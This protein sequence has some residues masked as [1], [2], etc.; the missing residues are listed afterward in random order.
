MFLFYDATNSS[1]EAWIAF[2]GVIVG[3]L[4]TTGFNWFLEEKKISTRTKEETRTKEGKCLFAGNRN[5]IFK[6]ES[7]F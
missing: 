3:G 5:F 1:S 4:I 2:A 7:F 6:F